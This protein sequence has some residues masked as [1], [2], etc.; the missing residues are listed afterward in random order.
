MPGW[1]SLHDLR[2]SRL[3]SASDGTDGRLATVR[4]LRLVRVLVALGAVSC[5]VAGVARGQNL[6][7]KDQAKYAPT[8]TSRVLA[9]MVAPDFTLESL[10]G[11]AVTLS[12]FRGRQRVI[13]VFYRG[14]W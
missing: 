7:P 1:S 4:V 6:G 3:S 11:P 13:L 2:S 9:G 8:D 10:G 12:A 5:T 14:H